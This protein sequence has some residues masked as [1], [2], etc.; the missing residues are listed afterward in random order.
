MTLT[1]PTD[2]GF[3]WLLRELYLDDVARL[4]HVIPFATETRQFDRFFP[5]AHTIR[6]NG[7]AV[8]TIWIGRYPGAV[9][10]RNFFID[11][12]YRGQG[13]GET[14]LRHVVNTTSGLPIWL[15]VLR[16]NPAVRLYERNGFTV[17]REQ[18][19]L[20]LMRRG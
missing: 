8:G 10:L 6:F 11:P 17:W 4:G 19:P 1:R 7:E 15:H 5:H 13:I 12:D 20:L 16:A 3:A 14:V 2:R 9:Y 18:G